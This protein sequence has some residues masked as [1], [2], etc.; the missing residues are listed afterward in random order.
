MK[1]LFSVFILLFSSISFAIVDMKNAN[2][3]NTWVDLS[4]PGTGYD[5]KISRTYNSRSLFNGMFGFGW[6]SDFETN[7]KVNKDNHI[8]LTE[9][10]GG[11][12][13]TFKPKG[14]GK[15]NLKEGAQLFANGTEVEN[16]KVDKGFYTR[17]LTDGTSQRF[18]LK[19]RLT[20][21]YD[22]NGNFLKLDY[23]NTNLKTVVDNNGRRLE[24][25]Y[26]ANKRLAKII[27]PNSLAADYTFENL[28]DLKLVK[29][30]WGN[31]Y[32]YEYD[33][34][35]NL[36][37]AT[38]PDNT[39]LALAYDKKRDWVTSFTD[40][41]GCIES[42]SYEESKTDARNHYWSNVKKTCGKEIVTESKYE[43]WHK[44]T[45]KGETYLQRVASTVNGFL[46]D[47]TYHEKFG[48]PIVIRRNSDVFNFD[49]YENGQVKS[50]SNQFSR[51]NYEYEKNLQKVSKVTNIF[52]NDKGK[53]V[54]EKVSTFKYDNKG[55]LNYAENTDG[56]K[57][58]LT[59]DRKGRIASILDQAKKVVKVEYDEKFGKPSVIT[60][61][62]LGTIV[63]TYKPTGE[64]DKTVSKEGPSVAMQVASTFNNLLDVIAPATNEVFL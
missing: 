31:T 56:Q 53:K 50:K 64:I 51:Q 49:Y 44:K 16:F 3:A 57:I 27:G 32:K 54:A 20:H 11:L 8:E 12:E 43:F 4:V 33:D 36:T 63:I 62:E 30:S 14:G 2:Y 38:Y 1:K 26:G 10:G 28:D 29:N 25:K 48:K 45:S 23:D 7:I 58:T 9:C 61:P 52:F 60:R 21:M 47:I 34:L 6:C 59:Y 41:Q 24:F 35:H 19:G 42:Y 46:T 40:R 5:L 17:N 37:K 18:D 39:F 22:K 15:G 13:I 55:N